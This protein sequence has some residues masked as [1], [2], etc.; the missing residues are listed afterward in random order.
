MYKYVLV[1]FS[2]LKVEVYK[3]WAFFHVMMI[4]HN[5]LLTYDNM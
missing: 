3:C 2:K 1:C 4:V 5:V